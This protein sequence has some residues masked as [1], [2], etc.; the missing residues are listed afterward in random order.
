MAPGFEN[1]KDFLKQY[2][3]VGID[4]AVNKLTEEYQSPTTTPKR[5]KEIAQSLEQLEIIQ[6]HRRAIYGDNNTHTSR[7]GN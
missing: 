5:K 6:N 3:T 1:I 4:G 7:Q 2:S